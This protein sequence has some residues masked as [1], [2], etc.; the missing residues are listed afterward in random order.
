MLNFDKILN[1]GKFLQL[2][3]DGGAR[4]GEKGV[5]GIV[6][7]LHSSRVLHNQKPYNHEIFIE[8]LEGKTQ[9]RGCLGVPPEPPLFSNF[10]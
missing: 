3:Q 10:D 5:Q 4:L 8:Y 7:P 1:S 6:E 9:C 2:S